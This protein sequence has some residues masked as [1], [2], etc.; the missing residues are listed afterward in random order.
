MA[1]RSSTEGKGVDSIASEKDTPL[2]LGEPLKPPETPRFLQ[3]GVCVGVKFMLS[4]SHLSWRGDRGA[5][6]VCRFKSSD[7]AELSRTR[8]PGTKLGCL[9]REEE[10]R[11]YNKASR[12]CGGI[13]FLGGAEGFDSTLTSGKVLALR[14]KAPKETITNERRKRFWGSRLEHFL[15]EKMSFGPCQGT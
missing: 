6:R 1:R 4:F 11:S 10:E 15:F 13:L 3:T 2:H 9:E 8:R 14:G 5:F 7:S 12:C